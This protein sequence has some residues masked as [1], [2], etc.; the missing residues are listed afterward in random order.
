MTRTKKT[1]F[2]KPLT[3]I[4][5]I[6]LGVI[7]FNP[8]SQKAFYEE[9][10]YELSF[11]M[12]TLKMTAGQT[13]KVTINI[14]RNDFEEPIT[15]KAENLPDGFNIEFEENPVEGDSATAWI[16][17]PFNVLECENPIVIDSYE[18]PQPKAKLRLLINC[19]VE[20]VEQFGSSSGDALH[21]D[22][23]IGNAVTTDSNGNIYVV[24]STFGTVDSQNPNQGSSDVWLAKYANDGTAEWI[25]QL[26]GE[27]EDFVTEV[28]AD[29]QGNV[30]I[31]GFTHG[32]MPNNFS[33]GNLDFWIAKYTSEGELEWV[34]QGGN[35]QQDGKFGMAIM[36][37]NQG[38][39][40]LATIINERR[41]IAVF[42]YDNDGNSSS[43]GGGNI[44]Q[45]Y[46][47]SPRDL[48]LT[49]NGEVYLVGFRPQNGSNRA[50][51]LKF[52][53][54]T[55]S[56]PVWSKE[57]SINGDRDATRVIVDQNGDIYIAGTDLILGTDTD[58]WFGKFRGSDGTAIWSGSGIKKIRS[59]L[60]QEDRINTLGINSDGDLV[61]AGSTRG[62]LGE[63]N[64]GGEDAWVASYSSNDGELEWINQFAV[65]NDD[66]FEA[67]TFDEN[68][69]VILAG[70]TIDWKNNFGSTDALLM[71][72]S[73]SVGIFS[74][75]G[76]TSTSQQ[77][78]LLN[79]QGFHFFNVTAVRVNGVPARIV[80]TANNA[81]QVEIP[82]SVNPGQA[83]L[84]I[85]ANCRT[86]TRNITIQ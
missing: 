43:A 71:R 44:S 23:D 50:Y 40:R 6:L 8:T 27:S 34:R 58:A 38:G 63:R 78:N 84:T 45:L 14:K 85:S 47:N 77:G 33:R 41:N 42:D 15:L 7:A 64:G 57:F 66:S 79:I 68:E 81:I 4:F 35:L 48:A 49:E 25:R 21:N 26:G 55:S 51:I 65:S 74:S 30:F 11:E 75:F 61:I 54:N 83:T 73:E 28:A 46:R 1:K 2:L 13:A 19:G 17:S 76:I 22:E 20:W 36:P 24:G 69:G 12:D 37:D 67:I 29:E 70:R 32:E 59:Q 18:N 82:T 10:S 56:Q 52:D 72:F 5:F 80:S 60:N 3:L 62:F 53:T 31:G 16:Y 9:P 86:V 39:A